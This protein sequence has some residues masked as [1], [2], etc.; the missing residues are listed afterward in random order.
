MWVTKYGGTAGATAANVYKWSTRGGCWS[1]ERAGLKWSNANSPPFTERFLDR[2]GLKWALQMD[3]F[4][5]STVSLWM[6]IRKPIGMREKTVVA[7]SAK[8]MGE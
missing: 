6:W 3:G 7:P 8:P 4:A 5:H 2:S 1:R